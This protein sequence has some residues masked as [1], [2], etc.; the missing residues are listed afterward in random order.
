MSA[1]KFVYIKSRIQIESKNVRCL[2]FDKLCIQ[3]SFGG[4]TINFLVKDNKNS[5][6]DRILQ[7][8]DKFCSKYFHVEQQPVVVLAL[9]EPLQAVERGVAG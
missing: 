1:K 6:A 7:E 3:S 4:L 5:P 9:P 2:Y 8:S